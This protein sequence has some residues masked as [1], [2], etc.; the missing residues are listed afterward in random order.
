MRDLKIIINADDLG[1]TPAVNDATFS[2]MSDGRITSATMMANG[3]EIEAACE[4]A[5]AFPNCSF[6]VHLNVTDHYPLSNPDP[7]RRILDG[8]GKFAGESAFRNVPINSEL[9]K[10]IVD[11]FCAQIERIK[12]LGISVSHVDSH[13]HVHT[14]PNMFRVIKATQKQCDISAIRISRNIT[15]PNETTSAS[16]RLKK[17]A[18]N[19]AL[20][21]YIKTNTTQGFT[22]FD[23][24]YKAA[25]IGQVHFETVEVMVHPGSKVY[26]EKETQL[27]KTFWEHDVNDEIRFVNFKNLHSNNRRF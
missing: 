12:S 17:W 21:H 9:A 4:D 27:L 20:R 1:E 8:E 14:M 6:G 19:F 16:L 5:H 11:E 3:P 7:L 15:S 10:A 24:F 13:H 23:S 18:Y 22:D 25:I 26:G 2:L